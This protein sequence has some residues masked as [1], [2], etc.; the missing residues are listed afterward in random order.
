MEAT[1]KIQKW[2]N[3]QGIRIPKNILDLLK[4]RDN[5]AVEISAHN[6]HIVIKRLKHAQ[7]KNINELFA[8]FRGEYEPEVIDWGKPEGNEIW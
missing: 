6:G 4:W 5:E 8:D 2:G 7:R 1:A 3:S